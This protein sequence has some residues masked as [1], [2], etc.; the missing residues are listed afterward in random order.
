MRRQ[1]LLFDKPDLDGQL[2]ARLDRIS[3]AVDGVPREQF[4]ISNDKDLVGHIVAEFTVD[5]LELQDDDSLEQTETQVDVSG[6]PRRGFAPGQ[7]GPFNIPGTRIDVK[8]PFTGE[9]WIFE[10]SQSV[11]CCPSLRRGEPGVSHNLH[12]AASRCRA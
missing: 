7:R 9:E 11:F 3:R 1:N 6:D 5:P 10:Y 4:L 12:L 2:R 8:I